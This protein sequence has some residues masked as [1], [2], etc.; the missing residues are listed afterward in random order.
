MKPYDNHSSLSSHASEH[1]QV[2]LLPLCIHHT[3]TDAYTNSRFCQGFAVANQTKKRMY[4][5]FAEHPERG[6]KF[7]DSMT[8]F[9]KGTGYE[10]SHIVN[11]I[12]WADYGDGGTVVDVSLSPILPLFSLSLT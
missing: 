9:T 7:G 12:P 1:Q 4:E 8:S 6:K 10:L 3:E 2:C 11:N 5:F